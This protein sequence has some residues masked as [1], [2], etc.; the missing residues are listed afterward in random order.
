MSG[1]GGPRP[2][3]PAPH[4]SLP[5]SLAEETGQLG[6]PLHPRSSRY[7]CMLLSCSVPLGVRVAQLGLRLEARLPAEGGEAT[8]ALD[9]LYGMVAVGREQI[10]PERSE[11]RGCLPSPTANAE[12]YRAGPSQEGGAAPTPVPKRSLK[13]HV[14][15]WAVVGLRSSCPQ[16]NMTRRQKAE[17]QCWVWGLEKDKVLRSWVSKAEPCVSEAQRKTK[18]DLRPCQ[19]P[20]LLRRAGASVSL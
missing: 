8:A 9:L 7:S 6:A 5:G 3:S 20:R 11:P 17:S 2:E 15:S 18:I 13:L 10:K 1:P 12:G 16:Q 19:K 14:R 4:R